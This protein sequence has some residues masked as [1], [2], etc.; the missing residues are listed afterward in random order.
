MYFNPEVSG[1][2]F[3]AKSL[4][5]W[6]V[7]AVEAYKRRLVHCTTSLLLKEPNA[8]NDPTKLRFNE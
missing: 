6:V 3:Q 5:P 7:Q 4:L 8:S 1:H 2:N